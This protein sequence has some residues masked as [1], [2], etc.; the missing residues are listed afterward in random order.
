M[1]R[2]GVFADA[3]FVDAEELLIAWNTSYWVSKHT[4]FRAVLHARNPWSIEMVLTADF[5]DFTDGSIAEDP[6]FRIPCGTSCKES[7]RPSA[8]ARSGRR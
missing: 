5:M 6:I 7:P 3:T 4:G 1:E 2:G 8:N